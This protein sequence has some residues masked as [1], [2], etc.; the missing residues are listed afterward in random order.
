MAPLWPRP[1]M[2]VGTRDVPTVRDSCQSRNL[3]V[4]C[5]PLAVA[6]RS[7]SLGHRARPSEQYADKL[8]ER[9]PLLGLD[10]LA[11]NVE[12]RVR[13]PQWQLVIDDV[14]ADDAQHLPRLGLGPN[15]AEE[16]GRRAD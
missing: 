3:R 1:A 15:R 4:N 10:Q 8:S 5:E 2:A 7:S 6:G 12:R 16:A 13:L 14:G 9:L 11:V